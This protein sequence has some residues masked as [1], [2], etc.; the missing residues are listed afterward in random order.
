MKKLIVLLLTVSMLLG[1]VACGNTNQPV[2]KESAVTSES[3]ATSE[4]V[5][6]EKK[7]EKIVFWTN[8][9]ASDPK[10]STIICEQFK[11]ATGIEL[12]WVSYPKE[13]YED[14]MMAALMSCKEDELP[15]IIAAPDNLGVLLR[16]EML[17]DLSGLIENNEGIKALIERNPSITAEYEMSDGSVYAL[18]SSNF[19]SMTIW[20][21]QDL[22]DAIGAKQPTTIDE[23][24]QLLRDVKAAYPDMIPLT[25]PMSLKVLEVMSNAFGVQYSI[26]Q[27][28]N[29]TFYDPTLT[30]EYKTFMDW[31]KMLYEEGL[32]DKELPTNTS[33]GAIRSKYNDGKAVMTVMWDNTWQTFQNA[34]DKN[35]EGKGQVGIIEP[36]ETEE[37]VFG[38][39]YKNAASPFVMTT[40]VDPDLAQQIF[41]AFYGWMYLDP[42]GV[43]TSSYGPRDYSW[44]VVDGKY[45]D[46]EGGFDIGVTMQS[47]PP[48]DPDFSYEFQ[49][50]EYSQKRLD[51]SMYIRNIVIEHADKV[52]KPFL[53]FEHVDYAGIASDLDSYRTELFYLYITGQKDYDYFVKEYSAR[54]KEVGLEN[55]LAGMN[56]K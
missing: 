22:L 35:T 19:Q 2:S 42:Q 38:V 34:M 39:H 20:T 17:Y 53:F 50:S 32:I 52:M 1:M 31:I 23:F 30:E 48:V 28:K 4:T 29:G 44:S 9:F 49:I 40:G 51:M 7:P 25:S 33:Y 37:G 3:A 46:N 26:I 13:D 5:V 27:D 41:D 18:A 56:A 55:I 6:E 15:D 10:V 21:R 11:E 43:E 12:E 54:I 14:I 36:F 24:T 45:K 8:S 47:V 16:Q